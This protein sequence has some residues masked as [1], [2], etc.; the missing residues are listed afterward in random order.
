MKTSVVRLLVLLTGVLLGVGLATARAEDL[1]AVKAR[2]NQ[3]LAQLD[4][5]KGSGAVGENNRGFVEVRGAG[6]DAG[7]VVS[8]ENQDRETVYAAIAKQTGSTPDQVGR[9]RAQRI[10]SSSAP[11][12]WLQKDDGSWYR[13]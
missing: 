4:Q 6:A 10:A 1:G 2:M 3:R 8:A 9:A 5:L 12:V 7:A 11:G 13:K